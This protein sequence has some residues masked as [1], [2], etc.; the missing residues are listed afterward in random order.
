MWANKLTISIIS[1]MFECWASGVKLSPLRYVILSWALPN[2]ESLYYIWPLDWHI[3][4]FKSI[5]VFYNI[6]NIVWNIPS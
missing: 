3:I 2:F 4:L 6:G 1:V 5:I